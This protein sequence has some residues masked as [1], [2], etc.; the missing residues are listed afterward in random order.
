[1]S[2]GSEPVAVIRSHY[3]DASA[4][5]KLL[6]NEEGS[7]RLKSYSED[8]TNFR[9]TTICFVEA[10]GVLKV[11]HFYRNELDKEGYFC[12]AEILAG[13]TSQMGGLEI[14]EVNLS[15]RSVFY[16]V[17]QLCKKYALHLSDGLQLFT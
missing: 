6:V 17:E 9:T 4:I 5:V 14:E 2:A 3:L 13:W 11:K 10:L 8:H 15:D 7:E 16:E 12:A 1:M